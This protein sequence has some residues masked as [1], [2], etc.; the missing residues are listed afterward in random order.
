MNKPLVLIVS[1]LAAALV[2][3]QITGCGFHPVRAGKVEHVTVQGLS[4]S[5]V[6]LG[7][8]IPIENPNPVSFKI[9]NFELAISIDGIDMGNVSSTDK[10][11]VKARSNEVHNFTV[12]A[13]FGELLLAIPKI[14][15]ALAKDKAELQV[16]GFIKV[17]AG[18]LAKRIKINEKQEVSLLKK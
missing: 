10:I 3:V 5:G 12:E 7:V 1:C 13:T 18:I 9:T 8:Q 6:T 17:K 14:M 15:K 16:K 4:L 11:K 2:V